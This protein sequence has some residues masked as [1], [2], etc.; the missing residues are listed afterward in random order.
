MKVT[1]YLNGMAV[2]LFVGAVVAQVTQES[3]IIIGL[4]WVIL[5]VGMIVRRNSD[6]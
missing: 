3:L 6:A 2:G 5:I 1:N 4:G